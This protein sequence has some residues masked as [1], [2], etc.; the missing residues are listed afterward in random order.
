MEGENGVVASSYG[1]PDEPE[2]DETTAQYRRRF[3]QKC[4]ESDLLIGRVLV[5][6]AIDQLSSDLT[7]TFEGGCQL[8]NF[9]VDM[10]EDENWRFRDGATGQTYRVRMDGVKVSGDF[11]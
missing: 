2:E 10:H 11:H 4:R 9:A 5:A 1:F 7:L 8:R 3:E 6:V